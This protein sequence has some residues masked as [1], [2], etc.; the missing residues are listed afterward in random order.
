MISRRNLFFETFIKKSNFKLEA[1]KR[2]KI[3]LQKHTMKQVDAL[4]TD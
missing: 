3:C 1:G 4:G 2:G